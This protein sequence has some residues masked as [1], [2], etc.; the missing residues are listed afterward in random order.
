MLVQLV[1][2]LPEGTVEIE[3]GENAGKTMVNANIVTDWEMI[4]GWDGSGPL[5]LQVD[6]PG[7]APTVVIVQVPGQG[8]ILA[9]ARL[10]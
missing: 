9:A 7:E 5:L 10:D 1:R 6:A 4:G 8:A 2:Y 3:S